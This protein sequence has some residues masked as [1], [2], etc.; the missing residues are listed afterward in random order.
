MSITTLASLAVGVY[1]GAE[2]G[3]VF[4]TEFRY[5]VIGYWLAMNIVV[6]GMLLWL[7]MPE[8]M[9]IIATSVI[10]LIGMVITLAIG[11]AI[12]YFF[13]HA[14]EQ[15]GVKHYTKAQKALNADNS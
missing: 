12:V 10:A 7:L 2:R 9:T 13:L 8:V 11:C 3:E 1:Y 4:S 15:L 6:G 5:Q 14:G